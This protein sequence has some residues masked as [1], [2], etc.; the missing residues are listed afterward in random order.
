LGAAA[1]AIAMVH[2]LGRTTSPEFLY[3]DF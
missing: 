3:F 1:L 2:I